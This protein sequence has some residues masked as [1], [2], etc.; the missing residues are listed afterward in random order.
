M[1]EREPLR[2]GVL[3]SDYFEIEGLKRGTT[4]KDELIRY[5]LAQFQMLEVIMQSSILRKDFLATIDRQMANSE[6]KRKGGQ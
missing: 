6:Q 4:D 2:V 3:V 5:G 1:K